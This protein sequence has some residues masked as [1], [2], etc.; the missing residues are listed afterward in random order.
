M[1]MFSGEKLM[2][3]HIRDQDSNAMHS[4]ESITQAVCP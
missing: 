4:Q 3:G 1:T 2:C